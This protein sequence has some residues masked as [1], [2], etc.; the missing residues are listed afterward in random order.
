MTREDVL[1]ELELLPV[2][3]LR[4]PVP[5]QVVLP[6]ALVVSEPALQTESEQIAPA[7]LIKEADIEKSLPNQ[8]EQA[9][10][11][12]APILVTEPQVFRHIT[13]E[14]GDWLFV[15]ANT[16]SQAD[17]ALLLRN[18]FMA[19]GVKA[20]PSAPAAITIDILEA[21]KPKL[22]IPMGE[23]AAQYLLQSTESLANLRGTVHARHGT[24]L[25][26][27]YDL[28][29]LLLTLPDKA[30]AWDDFCLAMQTLQRLKSVN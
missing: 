27:T 23:A 11:D 6:Q 20:K 15:L 17:E 21:T 10:A 30:K 12:I 16:A 13:S 4:A 19:I 18:I 28:A 26:A 2:W 24:A 7:V 1:R 5:S 25:V 29:H 22:V 3:Q 8:V 9:K 14:E